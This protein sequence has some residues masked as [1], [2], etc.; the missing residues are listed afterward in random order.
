MA[1]QIYQVGLAAM[2]IALGLALML[3]GHRARRLGLLAGARLRLLPLGS[4]A[5]ITNVGAVMTRRG[6]PAV[7]GMVR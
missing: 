3:A 7:L 5:L 2:I 1:W 4:A 6:V